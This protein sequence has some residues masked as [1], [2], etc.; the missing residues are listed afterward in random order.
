MESQYLIDT[1][2]IIDFAANRMEG[3]VRLWM[4]SIIDSK[5]SISV[6][7]KIE[8]LGFSAVPQQIINFV[9]IATLVDLTNEIITQT[10]ELR[11]IHRIK[12]PDAIIAASALSSNLVLVTRNTKD[13][14][15]V[16]NLQV[17]NPYDHGS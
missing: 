13:F 12:L 17:V 11:K 9:N 14:I 16:E 2:V 3:N 1:N 7:N 6:I 5:P 10:I 8:L 4:A 15:K